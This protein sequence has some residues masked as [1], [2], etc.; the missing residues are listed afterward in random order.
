MRGRAR[1]LIPIAGAVVLAALGVTYYF[2]VEP[3]P[4]VKVRWRATVTPDQRSDLEREFLLVRP[5]PDERRTYRYDLLDTSPS[6]VEALVHD[7]AVEDTADIDPVHYTWPP[8]YPYG[9][10]WTWAAD[11]V[12][13]LRAP[14]VVET[15]V[16]VSAVALIVPLVW[17]AWSVVSGQRRARAR[18]VRQSR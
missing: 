7:P 4:T 15:V 12:P 3:A 8:D 11:R 6:N 2:T 10:S 9:S 14:G 5:T 18:S 16:G 1:V 13:I 17:L